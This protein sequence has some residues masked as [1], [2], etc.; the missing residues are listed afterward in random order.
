MCIIKSFSF[1]LLVINLLLLFLNLPSTECSSSS[2][3]ASTLH[4]SP[5]VSVENGVAG[6]LR[7][8]TSHIISSEKEREKEFA[9]GNNNRSS[10]DVR[11]IVPRSASSQRYFTKTRTLATKTKLLHIGG[12]FPMESGSGGWPGGASLYFV[13]IVY[14]L[15]FILGI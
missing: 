10:D 13:I 8:G 11:T 15:F 14:V 5:D 7:Q 9:N 1:F 12:F 3:I 6:D 4:N 2:F